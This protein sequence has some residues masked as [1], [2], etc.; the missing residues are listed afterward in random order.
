MSICTRI[1]PFCNQFAVCE[2]RL[3][4]IE[5]IHECPHTR[6][7]QIVS[8]LNTQKTGGNVHENTFCSGRTASDLQGL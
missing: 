8:K 2:V 5:R 4:L 3:R 6:L 1:C 7:R